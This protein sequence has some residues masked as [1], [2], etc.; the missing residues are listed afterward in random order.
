[1]PRTRLKISSSS[2]RHAGPRGE[3][4]Y[5]ADTSAWVKSRQRSAP[6]W[7]RWRFDE[8]LLQEQIL[9]C[10]I[11][12]LELLHHEST[13]SALRSRRA[14][15]DTLPSV[16]IDAVVCA[17]ALQIQAGLG[18]RHGAKHRAVKL[19][20]Y[21][22]AAAAELADIT[23]LHYDPDYEAVASLTGQ[24]HEWIAPRGSL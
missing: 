5:L 8:L 6:A 22:I 21:L 14:D 3:L 1:M 18:E 7:L 11:V 2:A 24:R 13:P 4:A 20:G 23:V 9:T 12:K 10:D 19:P 16:P 15:L 17:R